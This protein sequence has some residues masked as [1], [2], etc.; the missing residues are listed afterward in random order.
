MGSSISYS[1]YEESYPEVDSSDC[2]FFDAVDSPAN[3]SVD[4]GF[5]VSV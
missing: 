5:I 4:E 3:R 2:E 1:I